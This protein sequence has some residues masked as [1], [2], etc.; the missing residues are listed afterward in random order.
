MFGKIRAGSFAGRFLKNRF[1]RVETS[2]S[3]IWKSLLVF[4]SKLIKPRLDTY[5]V[6]FMGGEVIP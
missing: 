5:T 3:L 6:S 1:T 2:V 4:A